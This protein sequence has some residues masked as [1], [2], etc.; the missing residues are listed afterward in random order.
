MATRRQVI[1]G[2]GR[3]GP[4]RSGIVQD[5]L[6]DVMKSLQTTRGARITPRSPLAVRGGRTA[7]CQLLLHPAHQHGRG[8]RFLPCH[9]HVQRETRYRTCSVRVL[10]QAGHRATNVRAGRN[11][12]LLEITPS[13]P[14]FSLGNS[15]QWGNIVSNAYHLELQG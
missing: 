6:Q 4:S 1:T 13:F 2:Q 12:F 15:M 11:S 10:A 3:V 14:G 9:G 7:T 5:K 8:G